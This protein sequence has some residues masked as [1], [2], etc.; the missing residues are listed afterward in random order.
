MGLGTQRSLLHGR[1]RSRWCLL[2][3]RRVRRSGV[4]RPGGL[5]PWSDGPVRRSVR[6]GSAA[7]GRRWTACRRRRGSGCTHGNT[8]RCRR[9][10]HLVDVGVVFWVEAFYFC[11][12]RVADSGVSKVGPFLSVLLPISD[13]YWC[14]KGPPNETR[15]LIY[16]S[17]HPRSAPRNPALR[18]P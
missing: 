13:I 4:D 16:A 17:L 7:R 18:P 3:C 5:T 6:S 8:G 2:S 9:G 12:G 11:V 1:R 15:R 10:S 14:L